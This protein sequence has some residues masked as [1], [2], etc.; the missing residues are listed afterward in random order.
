MIAKLFAALLFLY[1]GSNLAAARPPPPS[2][3]FCSYG[4][5]LEIAQLSGK[6]VQVQTNTIYPDSE[7]VI[8]NQ[9]GVTRLRWS[10]ASDAVCENPADFKIKQTGTKFVGSGCVFLPGSAVKGRLV[11]LHFTASS[12]L[13]MDEARSGMPILHIWSVDSSPASF[14]QSGYALR[15][16]SGAAL[17]W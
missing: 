15:L 11:S 6:A 16:G 4:L 12:R 5:C 9:V 10:S 7:V 2:P 14:W 17:K 8:H 1:S 13:T 3:N